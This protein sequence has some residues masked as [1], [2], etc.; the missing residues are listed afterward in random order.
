MPMG[1]APNLLTQI[2]SGALDSKS[3]VADLLRKCVALGGET[4][5]ARLRVWATRELKGFGPGDEL[6]IYRLTGSFLYLD[7][8]T[9][10]GRITGQ[11]MPINMIPAAAREWSKRDIEIRQPIAELVDLIHSHRRRGEDSVKLAPPGAQELVALI[12][13]DLAIAGQRSWPG[14][15]PSQVVERVYWEVGLNVFAG[16]IDTVRTTLVELVAEMRAASPGGTVPTREI[17]EQAV[18]VAVY[19]KVRRLVVNQVGAGGSGIAVAGGNAST[20]DA[21]PE[22][23][24]RRWMWWLAGIAAVLAAGA[25]I[26]ALFVH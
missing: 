6:P 7:G 3:D 11:Q 22:S 14:L 5:S 25:G 19:G 12:N 1:S 4:G 2:Q 15:P 20:G 13:H 26:A 8:V 24:P 10:R 18:D 17:A 21:Q 16:I 23:K 9:V